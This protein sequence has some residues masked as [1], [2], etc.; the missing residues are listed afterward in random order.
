MHRQRVAGRARAKGEGGRKPARVRKQD[1]SC[2]DL[3][4]LKVAQIHEQESRMSLLL[5][6][7]FCSLSVSQYMFFFHFSESKDTH[8]IPCTYGFHASVEVIIKVSTCFEE[9]YLQIKKYEFLLTL[10]TNANPT[11][12]LHHSTRPLVDT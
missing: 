1:E 12:Q 7:G 5:Y 10:V 8:T 11:F 3:E 9:Y 6:S 4:S 2:S